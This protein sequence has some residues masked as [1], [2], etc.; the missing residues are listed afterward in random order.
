MKPWPAIDIVNRVTTNNSSQPAYD[1]QM[2]NIDGT[3]EAEIKP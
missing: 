3:I 2:A 1:A